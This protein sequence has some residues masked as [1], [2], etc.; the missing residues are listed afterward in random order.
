[1]LR[2]FITPIFVSVNSLAFSFPE[3][4]R[5]HQRDPLG[6]RRGIQVQLDYPERFRPMV[7]AK[8]HVEQRWGEFQLLRELFNPGGPQMGR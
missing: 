5:T 6:A 2:G 3:S 1:M 7:L 4:V 8:P